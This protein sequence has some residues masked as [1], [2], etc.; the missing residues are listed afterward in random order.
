MKKTEPGVPVDFLKRT[1]MRKIAFLGISRDLDFTFTPVQHRFSCHLR[2]LI[3]FR[4]LR[5]TDNI[6]F[7]WPYSFSMTKQTYQICL[8]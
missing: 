8:I 5:I 4:S 3:F 7:H 2:N 1:D 6:F